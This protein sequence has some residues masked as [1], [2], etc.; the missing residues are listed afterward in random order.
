MFGK[1][2]K[3]EKY[4]I[5]PAPVDTWTKGTEDTNYNPPEPRTDPIFLYLSHMLQSGK[6]NPLPPTEDVKNAKDEEKELKRF[7]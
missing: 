3:N 7:Y 2:G 5:L 4:D 6:A 1:Y